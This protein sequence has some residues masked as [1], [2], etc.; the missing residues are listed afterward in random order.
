[1]KINS[2]LYG[3][4]RNF[5]AR[6][7]RFSAVPSPLQW[8]IS[9]IVFAP[10]ILTGLKYHKVRT[11]KHLSTS[12]RTDEWIY[13]YFLHQYRFRVNR[14][15]Y[16][17]SRWFK[18]ENRGFG[19]P[20]FHAFWVQVFREFRPAECLEIGVYRGQTLSLW[21]ML[22]REFRLASSCFGLSPLSESGDSV[23]KYPS[24]DYLEDVQG[25]F[26]FWGLDSPRLV[27]QFS[28]SS[29]GRSFIGSQRWDL[30]YIDGGHEYETVLSDYQAAATALK[31]GGVLVLDDSSL[32]D[33]P[34]NC[35]GSFAGHEG[36]SR[37]SNENARSEMTHLIRV[38]HLNAFV[39]K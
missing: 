20:A 1:M 8:Q 34:L 5:A 2:T 37:V 18:L 7:V 38:G 13:R 16:S 10:L 39:K 26:K 17:H 35:R 21:E 11:L 31:H 6:R 32:F 36:P 19:E 22:S 29:E 12:R 30:V 15:I 28:D 4:I 9:R 25:N 24:L 33:V 14:V 3:P 23:S 27:R